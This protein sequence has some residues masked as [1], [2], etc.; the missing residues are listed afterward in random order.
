[1]TQP[2]EFTITR[3]LNA[4]RDKVWKAWTDE[5]ELKK[6]FGPKG[7]P[8]TTSKINFTVG[9]SYHYGM[10]MPDGNEMW[11]RW[12]YREITAPSRA[13]W[14]SH[15]SDPTGTKITRHPFSPTWPLEMLGTITLEE[16]DGK[17]TLTLAMTALNTTDVERL[18]W[19]SSH[20]SLNMGWGGT[21]EQ[22]TAYLATT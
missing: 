9:G 13:V 21:F 12:V 16:H 3:I 4:P 1:M 15:F 10:R 22:L 2:T 8:I 14:E 17:T 11:G 18:T 19:D 7:M 6:W 20:A 5:N